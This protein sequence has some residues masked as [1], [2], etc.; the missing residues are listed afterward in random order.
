MKCLKNRA[1]RPGETAANY[2]LV[3]RARSR[4]GASADCVCTGDGRARR[5][6]Q[7]RRLGLDPAFINTQL[8]GQDPA[9]SLVEE[10][11]H[12]LCQC[13]RCSHSA[14]KLALAEPVAHNSGE[15]C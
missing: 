13:F 11:C 7:S 8:L 5:A 14:G 15:V 2:Q 12:W 1:E 10:V 4:A 3:A 9:Y 6:K